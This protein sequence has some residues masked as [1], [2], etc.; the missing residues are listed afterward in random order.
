[1]NEMGDNISALFRQC[2]LGNIC[3]SIEP[4]SG[5]LMHKMYK[6]R[7][8]TDTYAVKCLNPEVM[9]RPGVLDNYKRA[10]ALERILEK[11]CI[12]I[13]P[14]LSF[15]GKKMIEAGGRFYYIFHWQVGRI[16][17]DNAISKSQCYLAGEILGRIRREPGQ[18]M[19]RS[20]LSILQHMYRKRRKRTA[21]LPD[22]LQIICFF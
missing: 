13:V 11:E 4:V 8:E 17:D 2:G 19:L 15:E 16:T 12:P 6:V 21:A 22:F 3:G 10:E 1:M 7:T 14:A 5:G 9:K 20:A 18:K